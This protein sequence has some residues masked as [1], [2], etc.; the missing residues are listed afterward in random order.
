MLEGLVGEQ[1][2]VKIMNNCEEASEQF[3]TSLLVTDATTKVLGAIGF[4]ASAKVPASTK[5]LATVEVTATIEFPSKVHA[6]AINVQD[7]KGC[8]SVTADGI[9]VLIKQL[10]ATDQDCCNISKLG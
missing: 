10:L 9:Q 7:Q 8:N 2:Y 1:L 6:T 3:N 4:P 5:V